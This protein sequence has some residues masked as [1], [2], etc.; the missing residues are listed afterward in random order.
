MAAAGGE[1]WLVLWQALRDVWLWAEV[2]VETRREL[3][4]APSEGLY[5]RTLRARGE[6]PELGE[7]LGTFHLLRWTPDA[8]EGRH[9][10]M[11]CQHVQEWAE[12]RSMLEL[13]AAF[14]EAAAVADPDDPERAHL[15]ARTT[16]RAAWERRAALWYERTFRLAVR[17]DHRDAAVGAL[18]GYGMLLYGLGLFEQARP[19]IEQG[20]R[21]AARTG[22]RR[23]AAEAHHDL[24]L[25]SLDIEDFA[26]AIEHARRAEKLYPLHHPRL[27][28][29]VHDFA[30]VL[31]R[32]HHHTLAYS[33]LAKL[34]SCFRPAEAA[35]VWSTAAR[36]AAGS[37]RPERF[38]EAERNSLDLVAHHQ[39]H[40]AGAMVNLA[41]GARALR[42]WGKATRYATE[43]ISIARMRSDA[44]QQH[45]AEIVLGKVENHEPA[46]VDT[47][48]SEEKAAFA[49]RLMARLQRW[50]DSGQESGFEK[51]ADED[52]SPAP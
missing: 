49:R 38:E 11:A 52:D 19:F 20:A 48:V 8:V 44:G 16:R 4:N 27:P 31:V 45:L 13:A 29:L 42:E 33:L 10:A 26:T 46:L 12:A 24:I 17:A 28:G 5:G 21:R 7:V 25:L 30:V 47:P 41:E 34:P 14:A 35:I 23:K 40:G 51:G 3:F 2:D 50:K 36:A 6:A 18:I 43:A 22:R 15:A 37:G 9:V 39:E 1:L 32:Q